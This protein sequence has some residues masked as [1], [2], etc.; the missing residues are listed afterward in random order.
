M[1]Q[2]DLLGNSLMKF[3]DKTLLI[4]TPTYPDKN[5]F[6]IGS[7][8]VKNQVAILKNY[9]KEIYI[10]APIPRHNR[11]TK[12]GA[13]SKDYSYDNV[14]VYYPT[15]SSVALL[16]Y[17]EFYNKLRYLPIISSIKKTIKK[18]NLKID[19]IHAHF[20]Q[21]LGKVA[22]ILKKQYQVPVVLTIHENSIWFLKEYTS[23]DNNIYTA[24]KEADAVIRVNPFDLPKLKLYNSNCHYVANGYSPIF[25]SLNQDDCREKLGLSKTQK[26]IFSLGILTERKGYYYLI[27]A[28]SNLR[29]EFPKLQCYIGGEGQNYNALTRLIYDNQLEDMVHL[30]GFLPSE[31]LPLWMNACDMFVLPSLGEGNPTVMFEA[32]G[33]GKP[34]IGTN[35]GGVAEVIHDKKYGII[36]K[37][38]D[39]DELTDALR[40]GISIEWDEN[41]ILEYAKQYTWENI[42]QKLLEIYS[43]IL[44]KKS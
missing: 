18:N 7:I 8:F 37:P 17:I 25:R 30:L 33:C 20:T 28:M 40:L 16:G 32:L 29:S 38:G 36:C 39:V 43:N 21:P 11:F 5:D 4:L 15:Y 34:F 12:Q 10:I 44:E 35:V 23:C 3:K 31:M 42:V 2:N 1:E 22:C 27:K 26:I 41:I 24:W 13:Y 6:Y 19:L 9:F 14:S